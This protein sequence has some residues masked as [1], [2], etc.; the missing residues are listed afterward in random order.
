M[1]NKEDYSL[2]EA[3]LQ[4]RSRRFGKGMKL[5]SPL[6]Y[7]SQYMPQPLTL[8]QEALLSFA[9]SGVTGYATF[10]IVMVVF[11]PQQV[12]FALY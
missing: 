10:T 8:E 12:P 6:N 7:Q 3:M 5:G 4:R 1:A 2:I 9:A 11:L